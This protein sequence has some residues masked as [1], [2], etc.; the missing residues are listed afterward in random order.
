MSGYGRLL[1]IAQNEQA[2]C[3]NDDYCPQTVYQRYTLSHAGR[4]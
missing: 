1:F 2:N 4:K 3:N